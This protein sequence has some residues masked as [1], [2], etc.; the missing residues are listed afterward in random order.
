VANVSYKLAL[1]LI[2][3]GESFHGHILASFTLNKIPKDLFLDFK[4]RKVMN[5]IING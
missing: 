3:G 5:L 4:G 2:A 1:A